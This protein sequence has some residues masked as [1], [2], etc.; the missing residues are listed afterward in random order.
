MAEIY[1][2]LRGVPEAFDIVVATPE[3]VAEYRDS[4]GYFLASALREGRT[5]YA[6]P[7][8]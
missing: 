5:V 3:E 2:Q 6:S 7:A 4:P 8:M 1:R